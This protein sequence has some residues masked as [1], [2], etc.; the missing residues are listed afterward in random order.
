[1]TSFLFMR[2]RKYFFFPSKI[3]G[4]LQYVGCAERGS[5][6]H[7]VLSATRLFF[8]TLRKSFILLSTVVMCSK[9]KANIVQ[10]CHEKPR[11]SMT[12]SCTQSFSTG[13]LCKKKNFSD[14]QL[15]RSRKA[16]ALAQSKNTIQCFFSL[17]FSLV[18]GLFIAK[19]TKRKC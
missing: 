17:S 19:K 8:G 3:C 7:Y 5:T 4:N 18:R 2:V 1:M 15:G 16:T 9:K 6:Y 12:S 14:Q 13:I 10:L 11:K